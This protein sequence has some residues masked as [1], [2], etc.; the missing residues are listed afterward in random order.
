M[1]KKLRRILF[2]LLC[3]ISMARVNVRQA[4]ADGDE[5]LYNMPYYNNENPGLS[6]VKNDYTQDIYGRRYGGSFSGMQSN[7]D[8]YADFYLGG[9]YSEMYGVILR[10]FDRNPSVDLLNPNRTDIVVSIYKDG[11]LIYRS[12]SVNL[13]GYEVQRFDLDINGANTIRIVI[14]GS[15]Y[16][17][18]ADVFLKRRPA[19][20]APPPVPQ[21]QPAVQ[22]VP[23]TQPAVQPVPQTQPAVQPVPQTQPAPPAG[24]IPD[25]LQEEAAEEVPNEITDLIF[26]QEMSAAFKGAGS[27]SFVF[28]LDAPTNL[29]FS[30]FWTGPNPRP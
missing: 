1:G 8:N 4:W 12:G 24:D 28:S 30:F 27:K 19:E 11:S 26:R 15:L 16:I 25:G 10:N 7:A 9:Q 5:L 22:P 29:Y 3:V 17:R 14:N 6:L 2:L 18:L 23:Q 13:P 21:T 20:T